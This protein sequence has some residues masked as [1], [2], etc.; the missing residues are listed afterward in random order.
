MALDLNGT[1]GQAMINIT[2]P[3]GKWFG[4]GL[5]AK[6]FTMSDQPYTIVVDGSGKVSELKLG[7]HSGGKNIASSVHIVS[8]TVVDGRRTV[9]LT[10]SLKVIW[11]KI[12][13][14]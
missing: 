2:G 1:T 9:S 3:D 11:P 12:V 4:V 7:D 14:Y 6:T 8:N 10:R 5:G 13:S